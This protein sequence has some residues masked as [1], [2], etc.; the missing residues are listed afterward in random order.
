[1]IFGNLTQGSSFLATAGLNAATS[2]R[3]AQYAAPR[4]VKMNV[5]RRQGAGMSHSAKDSGNQKV[6]VYGIEDAYFRGI[7]AWKSTIGTR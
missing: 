6:D 2:L 5:R 3:L 7:D 1:M 4:A